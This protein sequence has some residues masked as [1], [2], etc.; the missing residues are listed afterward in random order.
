M[1]MSVSRI[2]M[3]VTFEQAAQIQMEDSLARVLQ[4]M[5]ETAG[6]AQVDKMEQR[7]NFQ[8]QIYNSIL[9]QWQSWI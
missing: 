1:L 2:P 7:F 8:M 4:D 6:L 3:I 5:Q 9:A